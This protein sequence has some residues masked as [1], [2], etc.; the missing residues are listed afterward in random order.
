MY[1]FHFSDYFYKES[2][3]MY[4]FQSNTATVDLV[5]SHFHA[6]VM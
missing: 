4:I 1:I 3:L 2:D 6:I 5:Y